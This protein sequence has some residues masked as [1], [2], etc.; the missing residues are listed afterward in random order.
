MNIKYFFDIFLSLLFVFLFSPIFI[1]ISIFVKFSSEGPIFFRQKRI[2]LGEREFKIFKFR[3][4][5][6]NAEK[7]GLPISTSVD[8][9]ITKTGHFLR[10]TKLDEIPQF[11]NVILGQMSLVGPRPEVPKYAT[12]YTD[13]QKRDIFSVRP[14]ITDLASLKFSNENEILSEAKDPEMTYINIILPSKL[15]ISIEYIRNK[16]FLLDV[17]ILILTFLRVIKPNK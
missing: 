8:P 12:Y 14:G 10:K 2:G 7:T 15:K 4:M 13:E 17:K 11:F 16:S 5:V 9:R 3:T 1:L 6:Q